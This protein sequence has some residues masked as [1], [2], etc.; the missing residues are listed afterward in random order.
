MSNRQK[1]Q[2]IIR[3]GEQAKKRLETE[4]YHQEYKGGGRREQALNKLVGDGIQA[5]EQLHD[6]DF[7][8]RRTIAM[9]EKKSTNRIIHGKKFLEWL[10]QCGIIPERC[11]R[12]VIDASVDSAVMIYTEHYGT[13]K[14]L[15]V[16]PPPELFGATVITTEEINDE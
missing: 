1:L 15:S 7:E 6:I 2:K 4:V 10:R 13:E 5:A 9:N 11:C 8:I 14:M 16:V 12:V 3:A